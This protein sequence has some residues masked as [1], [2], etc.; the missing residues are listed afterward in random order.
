M[1]TPSLWQSHLNH[2]KCWCPQPPHGCQTVPPHSIKDVAYYTR[3]QEEYQKYISS[4]EL[5]IMPIAMESINT[6]TTS[7]LTTDGK[8]LM[9]VSKDTLEE[10]IK[11]LQ[12][13]SK[14][15]ATSS[16][17]MLNIFSLMEEED[18]RLAKSV[19]M[20]KHARQD[21]DFS[22]WDSIRCEKRTFGSI[23]QL[24]KGEQCLTNSNSDFATSN[25]M[26]QMTLTKKAFVN[27]ANVLICHGQSID[28][29]AEGR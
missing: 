4:N 8:T 12:M 9:A 23:L 2:T 24:C 25:F 22:T 26:L 18:T 17:T 15:M 14:V 5:L 29:V 19:L 16:H 20:T 3:I 11:S 28:I 6:Q 1:S 21:V 10:A 27:I 13:T 7:L